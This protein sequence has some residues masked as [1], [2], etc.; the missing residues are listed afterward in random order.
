VNYT[1]LDGKRRTR[2]SEWQ[3]AAQRL[4]HEPATERRIILEVEQ[5]FPNH[6]AG[7]LAFGPDGM[8][9]VGLGDGGSRDDPNDNGQNLST[10]LGSMLR[11]DVDHQ[12]AARPYG[13]PRDNP[14]ANQREARGEIWAYGL[15]NPWR[16]SFDEGGR[17][18][19]ADV[20]QDDFEEVSIVS[21]GD[22][23][24]WR[25][26]EA[27]HCFPPGTKCSNKG[28]ADPVFEYPRSLGKSITGGYVY[29]GSEL[30]ELAG[31]YLCA[32]YL[33]GNLWALALPNDRSAKATGRLLGTW[34]RS[35]TTFGRGADGE[36]Y[37]GDF[38]SG[39][40]LKLVP[41]PTS[42]EG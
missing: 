32:D 7:Q 30:P 39:D 10:L 26:R 23:L 12:G 9:Y 5:P 17:L 22:N 15:R 19:V 6:N 8:L 24:G 3:L 2:V 16:Y 40:I 4:G 11:I 13:I 14:F 38:G 20:G 37:A 42:S 1:P 36:I 18:I 31:Q 28:Y 25:V 33:S 41:G 29:L 34:P 35:I 27:S 21:K